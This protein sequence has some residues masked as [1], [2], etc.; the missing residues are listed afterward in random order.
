MIIIVESRMFTP[1]IAI[2]V[3]KVSFLWFMFKEFI[4]FI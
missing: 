4:D 1:F 3:L 2:Q